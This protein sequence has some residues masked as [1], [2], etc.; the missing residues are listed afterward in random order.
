MALN[1]TVRRAGRVSISRSITRAAALGGFVLALAAPASAASL[2]VNGSFELGSAGF[3]SGYVANSD[4][5]GE[6]T[7]FL[8][9]SGSDCHP[10]WSAFGDHTSGTGTMMVV[11]GATS[12]GVEVWAVE[13]NVLPNTDYVFSGWLATVYP[14]SPSSLQLSINGVTLGIALDAPAAVGQWQPV[15][16]TWNSGSA[17]FAR[18][19]LVNSN[20]DWGGNDFAL[21]D[22]AF[23]TPTLH[24][25]ENPEPASLALL[26]IGLLGIVLFTRR[27]HAAR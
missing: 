6:G 3:S 11:N 26:G 8:T 15:S 19:V 7:Y 2:L 4:C 20:L 1:K 13:V 22:L 14:R 12:S 17:T 23:T 25:I 5:W 24:S 21:D 9:G 27:R 16:G 10:L 18:L